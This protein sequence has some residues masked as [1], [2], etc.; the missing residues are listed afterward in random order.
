MID[1]TLA[2]DSHV[3]VYSHERKLY[4]KFPV[5]TSP[6]MLIKEMDSNGFDKAIIV[7]TG[8]IIAEEN[9]ENNNYVHQ[10]VE[11]W[12]SRFIGFAS[13]CPL[14]GSA[15][16]EEVERAVKVLRLKGIKL[17]PP[18]GYPIDSPIVYPIVEKAIELSVPI[19][20]HSD[21]Y[22]QFC[23]PYQIARLAG[24]Y[25]D[26]TIIMAHYGMHPTMCLMVPEI[27]RPY[28]NIILDTSAAPDDPYATFVYP[29]REL[30][31]NRIVFGSDAL[32][33][34]QAVALKKLEQAEKRF[35]LTKEEKRHIL[36]KNIIRIL[37]LE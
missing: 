36:G 24:L 3:H 6:E 17:Y 29:I 37:N 22:S 7:N 23:S 5:N 1:G 21:F 12:P 30:G 11:K 8:S 32:Y 26:A 16:I 14:I 25:P 15:A 4:G 34:D 28:R 27:V 20:V 2:V 18:H 33:F 19:V 13:I 35:G 10:V 31:I 9:R